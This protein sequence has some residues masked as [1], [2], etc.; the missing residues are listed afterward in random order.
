MQAAAAGAAA[1]RQFGSGTYWSSGGWGPP[2]RPRR[3]PAALSLGMRWRSDRKVPLLL[4]AGFTLV[5]GLLVAA[6]RSGLDALRTLEQVSSESLRAERASSRAVDAAQSVQGELSE[7]Y[8]AIPT[9]LYA[10]GD[11]AA[12]QARLAAF[13]AH[14]DAAVTEWATTGE[15]ERWRRVQ[16]EVRAF[17][18]QARRTMAGDRSG[19]DALADLA[20]AHQRVLLA[21]TQ[22]VAA[23]VTDSDRLEA[24]ER[25]TF[26]QHFGR[27][28]AFLAVA[29]LLA[30]AVALATILLARH[31][32]RR[33]EWQGDE[34]QRLSAH[35]LETQESIV[36]RFS[37]ELHDEF[38]QTLSAIEANLVALDAR[39]HPHDI[40]GRIEDCIGLV[41]DV[42]SQAREMSQLLRPSILDDF[43]LSASLEWLADG[44]AQRTGLLVRY[45]S[46]FAGRVSD[47]AETHLFRIAQEALT[48]VVR[49]AHATQ[50]TI[51]L[52]HEDGG[53]L[54]LT[55]ADN[56]TGLVAP[57]RSP[58][59]LGLASMRARAHQVHGDLTLRSEP[60][61]GTTIVARVPMAAPQPVH[62][63]P[64]P[65]P[66]R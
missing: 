33:V 13:E 59:G 57:P 29:L 32:F 65:H 58:R 16:A 45:T 56:G 23:S 12:M 35:M 66:A 14:V 63:T 41:Q 31:L 61:H 20:Q 38:G 24:I 42:I 60:G 18:G 4:T 30:V 3:P 7:L 40:R 48:N 34:L 26:A 25:Q 9:L 10:G 17:T 28:R 36:R 64:N 15:A 8:Y 21:I 37:R 47:E 54:T 19:Q 49:H 46:T 55:I 44:V 6:D 52:E 53:Y 22:L 43:G 39:E 50:V 2:A 51:A 27:V 11:R 1:Y 62:A 5:I